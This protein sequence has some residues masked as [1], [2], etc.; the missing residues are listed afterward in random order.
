MF[1]SQNLQFQFGFQGDRLGLPTYKC[2]Y[3]KTWHE[4]RGFSSPGQ[5]NITISMVVSC[6]K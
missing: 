4:D 2:I 6:H 3:Q 1:Q 5:T